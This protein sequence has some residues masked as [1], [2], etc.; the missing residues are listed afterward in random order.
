MHLLESVHSGKP[1]TGSTGTVDPSPDTL[2]HTHPAWLFVLARMVVT[3]WGPFLH[4]IVLAPWLPW[5]S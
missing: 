4:R 3:D 1:Q 5:H 2:R